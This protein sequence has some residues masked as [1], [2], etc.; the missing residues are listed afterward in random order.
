MQTHIDYPGLVNLLDNAAHAGRNCL[1][2]QEVYQ[3]IQLIGGETPPQF[4]FHGKDD[5]LD[6]SRLQGLPGDKV[7]IKIVSEYILHKSDVG[8]VR[9]T[10][11]NGE[12]V[13]STI[14]RMSFEIPE[15]FAES[16]LR[17]PKQAPAPY[18]KMAEDDLQA[19]IS[20]DI[21][22]YLFCQYMPPDSEEFGNELLV[23]LRNSREFG[24]ILSAGLG[25]RD[26]ELYGARFRKG[27]AVVSASTDQVDG[28]AFLH[29]FQQTISY[30]KL[31][32][33][34]RGQKRIV[35]DNQL[36]ECFEALIQVAR[37]FSP[38]SS[39]SPYVIE[40]LEVN[41]FAFSNYL[42]MPLD[43]LCKFSTDKRL[44]PTRPI[45][46]IDRL[47]HPAT[48]SIVGISTKKINIGRIILDNILAN[49]FLKENLTLIHPEAKTIDGISTI[50]QLDALKEKVDLVILAVNGALVPAMIDEILLNSFAE[51]VILISGGLGEQQDPQR[52]VMHIQEKILAARKKSSRP[53]IFLGANSLG[54]LSQPGRYDALFI[55]DAKLPKT[56]GTSTRT[57]ALVSQSG[58]YT[59]TRMSTLTFLDPAYA[60][61]IGNQ[62]DL[63]AGDFMHFLKKVKELQTLAFYMEGFTDLD[64]LSFSQGVRDAVQSGKEVIFYKAGRTP[65]GK[66]AL[67]GLTASIA[68]DYMVCEFC[69]SQAGA[70]VAETFNVLEGLLR[71]SCTLHHKTISGNRLAAVSNAGYEA[72]GIADNIL[73][74]DYRLEMAGLTA[75]SLEKL[76]IILSDASLESL[77]SVHNPLDI[78][79]MASENVYLEVIAIFLEDKN[80]DAVIVAIV[81]LTP[82]LHTLPEELARDNTFGSENSMV[83][84]IS[85]LNRASSKPLIVVVDSGRLYDPMADGFQNNGLPVFRSADIAV[86][87]LG[88]Y[89]HNRL[90][91]QRQEDEGIMGRANQT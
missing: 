23:S 13:L 46:K 28:Q 35:T 15:K 30:K 49:G 78:T 80:T 67:S 33:L 54:I 47:L 20:A 5:R 86:G 1:F 45:E 71:L 17:H 63:T 2:E 72:V 29:L 70:M 31:A 7:V 56:R 24:M 73:G 84:R 39:F 64:G 65:E 14:R 89:M 32:G 44:P 88:K 3:F 43:G 90:Q 27:Q 41:P 36:L 42:M 58:A 81:P 68:G 79:P 59:I 91:Q 55:P 53:P 19:A 4:Y 85:A 50:P 62:L 57:T 37:R 25:G 10:D 26:T 51:S 74:E 66:N 82:L 16:I 22:G 61:S 76:R 11:K 6:V 21:Q 34:T 48:I 60:I 83:K 52:P 77:T 18:R 40:E 9:I 75:A 12:D 8:G 38:S 87:V 69:I